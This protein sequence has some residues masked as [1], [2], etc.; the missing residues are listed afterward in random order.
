MIETTDSCI[1]DP[2][3]FSNYWK[4][5]RTVCFVNRFVQNLQAR[6]AHKEEV[7]GPISAEEINSAERVLFKQAQ[8]DSYAAEIDLLK[9]GKEIPSE[10]PLFKLSPYLEGGILR[11][12]GRINATSFAHFDMKHPIILPKEHRITFLLVMSYH[13]RFH[14]SSVRVL[15][16]SIRQHCMLC[17]V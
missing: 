1:V 5:L 3:R 11:I 7:T 4:I 16:N 12:Q 15:V 17:K 2:S 6:V 10:S 9:K 13:R 8:G 14:I